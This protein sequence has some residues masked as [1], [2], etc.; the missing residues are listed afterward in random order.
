M[1]DWSKTYTKAS[2]NITKLALEIEADE[3]TPN[4]VGISDDN[5]GSDNLEIT[6]D[7]EVTGG[8]LTT[9][10]A[11]VAAH[12]GAAATYYT[13]YCY[14]CG[15]AQGKR[16][17]AALTA[18]PVC[19]G[20]DIQTAYHNDNLDATTNP[21]ASN[22]VTE[23]YCEGSKW[24]NV[25]TEQVFI[26]TDNTEDAAKWSSISV[27]RKDVGWSSD[28]GVD[29]EVISGTHRIPVM[30]ADTPSSIT[31]K[32]VR[33]MVGTA[34]TGA[35]IILDIHKNGT[36]IFTTQANRPTIAIDGNDSGEVTN[37][38]VTTLAKG[39]YLTLDVD[40]IGSTVAG[41]DLVVS[42]EME[43]VP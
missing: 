3:L 29:L 15:S 41:K 6:F 42:L 36:T 13:I 12:D 9:L 33:A 4:L 31:I 37:M 23:G 14:D 34:P 40:Q 16:A 25:S 21:G 5:S 18:C 39:D 22:D 43:I 2:V 24:I 11:T 30:F 17:L 20:T 1:A 10:D 28:K 19:S 8:E 38:D 27:I 7:A 32:S 26:C 35:A